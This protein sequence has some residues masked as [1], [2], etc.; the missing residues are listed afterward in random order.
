MPKRLAIAVV[1]LI[2]ALTPAPAALAHHGHDDCNV[3]HQGYYGGFAPP[4]ACFD[5]GD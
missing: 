1:T 4:A 5:D 2:A 3:V